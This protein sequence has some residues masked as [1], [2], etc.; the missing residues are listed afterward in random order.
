M[1]A[2]MQRMM[3]EQ[4]EELYGRIEHLEN[5]INNNE[6]EP[7]GDRRRQERR[8]RGDHDGD[9]REDRVKGV[10]INIPSF[11]G[12]N[13]PEAY[14]EWELKIEQVFACHNY[15]EDKKVKVAAMEFTD[16]A[17]IWW[18]QLQKEKQRYEEPLVDTWQEMKRLMR[19]RFIPSYYHRDLHNK[20]QRLT[21]G[22]RS[23][24]EY[25]KE[26]EVS[27]IRANISEDREATM[28]RFLHGL[29]SDIRDV[30]ELQN[31]VEL[32]DLVHQATKVEQQLKRKGAMRRNSSNFNSPSWKDRNKKEGST[33]ISVF[34]SLIYI[35]FYACS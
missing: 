24:D 5:Q 8:R 14:L 17:L 7:N 2:Q 15:T 20:L 10:K 31:Y 21:Q 22:N 9:Q 29:N 16:Y 33:L 35:L 6:G 19:R 28:A 11:K 27:L 1:T 30:V 13:D 25:Y 3:R 26:M 4:N 18:D 12:R 23:V 32:E 34:Y